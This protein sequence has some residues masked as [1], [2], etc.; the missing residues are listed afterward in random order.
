MTELIEDLDPTSFEV[1]EI[2][3]EALRMTRAAAA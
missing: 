3:S 2:V 1:D